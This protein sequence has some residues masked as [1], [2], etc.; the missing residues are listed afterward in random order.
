LE[1]TSCRN[2]Q[3]NNNNNINKWVLFL[4][5]EILNG[6]SLFFLFTRATFLSGITKA[7]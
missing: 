2:P 4:V 1:Q 7:L 6:Q 5:S 3:N